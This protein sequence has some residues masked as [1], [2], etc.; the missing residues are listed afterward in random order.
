MKFILGIANFNKKYGYANKIN[1]NKI[2]LIFT[3][4]KFKIDMNITIPFS[5]NNLQE[6]LQQVN[7]ELTDIRVPTFPLREGLSRTLQRPP[8]PYPSRNLQM[9]N[10]RSR[11]VDNNNTHSCNCNNLTKIEIFLL[12]FTSFFLGVTSY[13]VVVLL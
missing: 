1:Y 8:T 9:N 4:I 12:L 7:Q 2:N 6:P 11:V 13:F 10:R 5:A 3:T